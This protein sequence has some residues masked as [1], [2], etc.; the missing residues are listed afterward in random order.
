MKFI[1]TLLIS[2]LSFFHLAH[3]ATPTETVEYATESVI[4]ELQKIPAEGRNTDEV[5]RLV[6]SYILP[7]IDQER[8]AKLAL[9]KH[10]RKAT[11]DQRSAFIDTFRAV[12]YTHLTLPTTPYV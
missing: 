4:S 12:S 3:A 11:K 9:G 7:A 2:L 8:I 6:E 10:W 5:K 1:A